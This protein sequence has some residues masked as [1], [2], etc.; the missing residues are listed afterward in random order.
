MNKVCFCCCILLNAA[1]AVLSVLRGEYMMASFFITA[2]VY[3]CLALK[4]Q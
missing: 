1:V 3:F 2:T 4:Q